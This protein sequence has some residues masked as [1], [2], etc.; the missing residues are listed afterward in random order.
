VFAEISKTVPAYVGLSYMKLAQVEPQFPD[1]GGRDLYYGG[2]AFENI[3]GL[4]VQTATGVE[5]GEAV[6][7]SPA[8]GGTVATDGL[9]AVPTTLLYDRGTTFYRSYVMHPRIPM[10]YVEINSADAAKLGITDGETIL[11]SVNGAESQVLARVDG[12]APA[13]AVLVPQSLG[14][15]V[16]GQIAA[17]TV[18]KG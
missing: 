4:G 8:H 15:P 17:A 11:L 16:L 9:V 18:K 2:T 10:P 1:V 13:G 12:R 7:T 6:S 5:R 14:G 3:G